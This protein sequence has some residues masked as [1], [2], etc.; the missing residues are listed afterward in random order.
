MLL[1]A[2]GIKNSL[3]VF[4]FLEGFVTDGEFSSLRTQGSQRPVSIIQLIMDAKKEANSI[5][6]QQMERFLRPKHV[7]KC[8]TIDQI[9]FMGR[10]GLSC[11]LSESGVSVYQNNKVGL[12][13][14]IP[15]QQPP[16]D[17]IFV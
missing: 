15:K 8:M 5:S 6:F 7:G 13:M 12:R 1:A 2:E 11:N 4:L 10:G 3:H 9:S 14:A 17:K 16:F